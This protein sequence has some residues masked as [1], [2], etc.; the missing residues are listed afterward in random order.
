MKPVVQ[1]PERGRSCLTAVALQVTSIW[2][3][4]TYL[5]MSLFDDHYAAAA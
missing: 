5:D 1:L 3:D 2:R 4:R